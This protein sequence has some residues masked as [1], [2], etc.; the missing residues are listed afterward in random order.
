MKTTEVHLGDLSEIQ[1]RF[2]T[3]D[4]PELQYHS[5]IIIEFSGA[6]GYGASSNADASFMEGMIAAGFHAW[7][8]SC[9]ILDLRRLK[10]EWGDMMCAVINPPHNFV[11][12]TEEDVEYPFAVVISDLNREGLTSLVSQE[13]L[14]DPST[15]LFDTLEAAAKRVVEIAR[16]TYKIA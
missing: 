2:F 14:E 4:I 1:C 6:C 16:K 10:Y 9:C 12:I 13:M 11:S 8:P 7:S 3:V 5:A 15:I